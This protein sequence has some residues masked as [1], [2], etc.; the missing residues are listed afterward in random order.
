MKHK[1]TLFPRR[2]VTKIILLPKVSRMFVLSEGTLHPFSLPHLE[3]LPSTI[4]QPLRGIVSAVLDD[5]EL[6]WNGPGSE[7]KGA[8]MTLVVVRRK[9]LGIY[10]LGQRLVPQKVR[11]VKQ[12]TAS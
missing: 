6:E 3:L 10:R 9:G 7:D 12:R 2:P 8:E 5:E 1:H 11:E 4:V